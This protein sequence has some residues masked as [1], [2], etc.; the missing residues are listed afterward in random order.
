MKFILAKSRTEFILV[1]GK[2][3]KDCIAKD[4]YPERRQV[5]LVAVEGLPLFRLACFAS[6]SPL[7]RDL[8]TETKG[9]QDGDKIPTCRSSHPLRDTHFRVL[10][11]RKPEKNRN[12]MRDKKKK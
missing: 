11:F 2:T 5:W 8:S 7:K 4:Y 10:F 6:T 1:R 3:S 12:L 9:T